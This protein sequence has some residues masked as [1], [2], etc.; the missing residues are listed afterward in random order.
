MG[1][2]RREIDRPADAVARQ[3][4]ERL[5]RGL[6]DLE[7][8]TPREA[9]QLDFAAHEEREALERLVDALILLPTTSV[10]L[11]EHLS[12]WRG[13]F[14]RTLLLFHVIEC[15]SAFT[16]NGQRSELIAPRITGATAKRAHLFMV[17]F[18]LPH[19]VKFYDT[20]FRETDATGEDTR[21]I[22]GHILAHK[23]ERVTLREI[24]RALHGGKTTDYRIMEAMQV[25]GEAGWLTGEKTRQDTIAWQVKPRVH[26][27]Y[28]QRA[29][30]EKAR[31]DAT[32]EAIR[33]AVETVKAAGLYPEGQDTE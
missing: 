31:R 6:V 1:E 23:L 17:K 28:A 9:V 11:K 33:K 32:R 25:L 15:V 12:K 10:A 19:A 22:A 4:Y 13:K 27:L 14:A 24:R 20:F 16:A 18:I 3:A 29:A 21:W 30:Q 2:R 7:P 8:P 5:L 26:D